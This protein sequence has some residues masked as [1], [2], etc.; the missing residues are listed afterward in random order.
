[1]IKSCGCWASK[2]GFPERRLAGLEQ[3]RIAPVRDRSGL[4]AQHEVYL[5]CAFVT[6]PVFRIR[7]E[8]VAGIK[9]IAARAPDC[10]VSVMNPWAMNIAFHWPNRFIRIGIGQPAGFID[11]P[12]DKFIRNMPAAFMSPICM[13][14]IFMSS[15]PVLGHECRTNLRR[16]KPE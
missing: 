16:P 2:S 12:D 6:H 9:L 4:Q 13:S 7:H 15:C 14:P 3:Q 8:P 1:M 10:R 5:K 11:V